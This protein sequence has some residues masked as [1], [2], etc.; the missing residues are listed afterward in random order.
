[1]H[2][3]ILFFQTLSSSQP[4]CLFLTKLNYILN[5]YWI[6]LGSLKKK[7]VINTTLSLQMGGL[8]PTKTW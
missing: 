6:Y 2:P 5:N 3:E 8:W 7:K 1:M 4:G